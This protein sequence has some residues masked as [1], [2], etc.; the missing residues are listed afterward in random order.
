M[1]PCV[2][3]LLVGVCGAV[4]YPE[5]INFLGVG[6]NLLE[7]NPDGALSSGGIDPGL[8][9]TRKI[10]DMKYES[11]KPVVFVG[12]SSCKTEATKEVIYSS[13]SY[14]KKLE[15]DVQAEGKYWAGLANRIKISLRLLRLLLW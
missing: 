13:K 1:Q 11:Y 7:G 15:V 8:L 4:A 12:R 6:Y 5:G 10:L 9:L 14:K 2:F 3:L